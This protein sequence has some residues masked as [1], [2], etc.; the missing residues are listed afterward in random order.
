M[1]FESIKEAILD[2]GRTATA[3]G[4]GASCLLPLALGLGTRIGKEEDDD[5]DI[6]GTTTKATTSEKVHSCRLQKN[7]VLG[8]KFGK[9][10]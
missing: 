5:D 2:A 7:M 10:R 6:R 9:K 8:A 3:A 1:D 4:S